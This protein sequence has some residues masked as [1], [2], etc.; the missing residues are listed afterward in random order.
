MTTMDERAIASD[1]D[2]SIWPRK[3]WALLYKQ[4]QLA[5][6]WTRAPC[7]RRP[8]IHPEIGPEEGRRSTSFVPNA[9]RHE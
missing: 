4:K 9:H 6:A 3:E 2:V 7:P 8:T 1:V 5:K